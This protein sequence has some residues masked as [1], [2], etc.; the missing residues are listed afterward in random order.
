MATLD[1]TIRKTHD[2]ALDRINLMSKDVDSIQDGY[3]IVQEF[4][5]WLEP[6]SSEPH[7]IFSLAY[8]G[9]ESEY[10]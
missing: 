9:D 1:S 7:E 10:Q 6:D 2:W 4:E 5:E 3:A 8:I